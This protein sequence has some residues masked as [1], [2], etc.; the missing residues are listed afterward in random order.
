MP[1]FANGVMNA[2]NVR[3]D[4][5]TY[6]GSVTADGQ[7]LIGSTAYPYIRVNTITPG[8]GVT[9]TNAPGSI[10]LSC[11]GGGMAWT[12]IGASGTLAVNNGYICTAGA[13]LSFAL[14]A[15]SAVG[16]S[17]G[18]SL[19]GSISWTVNQAANQQIRLGSSQTT[20]GAGGSLA[21]TAQGDTIQLICVVANLRWIVIAS[22]GNIT[23]V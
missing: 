12:T 9:V 16:D 6:P 22:M 10:T 18:L 2:D 13:A 8:P 11:T 23:I 1:G 20:L 15:V 7:L 5:T 17:I 14:P 3:F 4:G 21:S 19:D